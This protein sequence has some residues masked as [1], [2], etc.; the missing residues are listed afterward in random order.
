MELDV[1]AHVRPQRLLGILDP[2]EPR[3]GAAVQ[4]ARRLQRDAQQQVLLA[5]VVVVQA[6]GL[7]PDPRGDVAHRR[8]V[9]AALVE[10]PGRL[11]ADAR[12]VVSVRSAV[13]VASHPPPAAPVS[14]RPEPRAARRAIT[15]SATSSPSTGE[16]WMPEPPAPPAEIT[17]LAA[18]DRADLRHAVGAHRVQARPA[19]GERRVMSEGRRI[20]EQLGDR[21]EELGRGRTRVVVGVGDRL[22]ASSVCSPAMSCPGRSWR[23]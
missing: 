11:P 1:P 17:R 3:D 22:V 16:S 23:K 15:Q 9:V 20:G 21:L 6:P 10:Q 8:R 5:R 13:N 18:R 14:L 19:V 4:L 7:D 2:V 12:L